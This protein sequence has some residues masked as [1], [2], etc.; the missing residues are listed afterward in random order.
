VE[1]FKNNP[2][3]IN[4]MATLKRIDPLSAGKISALINLIFGLIIGVMYGVFAIIFG[5]LSGH[6]GITFISAGVALM[7]GAPIFYGLLGLIMGLLGAVI[8]NF[9]ASRF[10]GLEVEWSK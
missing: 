9:I 7:I 2:F 4:S 1:S 3:V 6:A 5:A 8:Y 10:G